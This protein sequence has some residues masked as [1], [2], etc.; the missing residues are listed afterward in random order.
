[1]RPTVRAAGTIRGEVLLFVSVLLSALG[2]CAS[3][4]KRS[5]AMNVVPGV[6]GSVSEVRTRVRGLAGRFSG[7]IEEATD[8][9]MATSPDPDVR[10]AM[11]L[12]K[13]NAIPALQE[14]LFRPDPLE[15]LFDA[16]V[17]VAQLQER[18]AG[19]DIPALATAQTQL[20]ETCGQMEAELEGVF[21]KVAP[22]ADIPA[23]RGR[24][25]AWAAE[26][27]LGDT[28]ASRVSTRALVADT[29]KQGSLNSMQ[30]IA[31]L[32][33]TLDD[34]M[35]RLDTYVRFIPKQARWQAELLVGDFVAGPEVRGALERQG[36]VSGS[37]D[38]ISNV[39]EQLPGLAASERETLLRAVAAERQ[40]ALE[41]LRRERIETLAFADGQ[42]EAMTRDLA[43]GREALIDEVRRLVVADA[44]KMRE[45]MVADA[46]DRFEGIVNRAIAR[47]AM[48]MAALGLGGFVAA[49]VLIR[50]AR[51]P[52]V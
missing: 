28:L 12:A 41:G 27:P 6:E 5:A 17:L 40:A 25:H 43:A 31:A 22:T 50:F 14:S 1:M 21:R 32:P 26:H 45:H 19:N 9:V 2:G 42:R 30:A 51:R 29:V 46:A 35:T 7:L 23:A 18:I 8:R 33:E 34:M 38:R 44:E 48:V 10:R 4:P 49:F 39:V 13:T 47:C 37:L 52:R 20:T 3:A 11:L 15:A 16:W 24:V 36:S